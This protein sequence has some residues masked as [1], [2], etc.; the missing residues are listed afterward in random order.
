MKVQIFRPVLILNCRLNI[1]HYIDYKMVDISSDGRFMKTS[2]LE[3]SN[4]K[5]K[6]FRAKDLFNLPANIDWYWHE[7]TLLSYGDDEY[8]QLKQYTD[9]ESDPNH[10][11]YWQSKDGADILKKLY[12]Y[13]V[14]PTSDYLIQL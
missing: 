14:T 4:S 12:F 6:I 5:E 3:K 7:I 13:I 11:P 9:T 10:Y 8:T 1:N 2:F